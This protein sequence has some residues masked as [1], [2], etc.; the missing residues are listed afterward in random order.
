MLIYGSFLTFTTTV[1]IKPCPRGQSEIYLIT[2]P[3]ETC[4][5]A[6]TFRVCMKRDQQFQSANMYGAVTFLS[7]QD[8]GKMWLTLVANMYIMQDEND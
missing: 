4:N 8:L 2:P 7:A 1:N 6:T 3:C 5:I